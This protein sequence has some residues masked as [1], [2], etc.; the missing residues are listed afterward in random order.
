MPFSL[1]RKGTCSGYNTIK[2]CVMHEIIANIVSYLIKENIY[3]NS[4]V[5]RNE[6]HPQLI[7]NNRSESIMEIKTMRLSIIAASDTCLIGSYT[8]SKCYV[9]IISTICNPKHWKKAI[10]RYYWWHNRV[11]A[12]KR[13][14]YWTNRTINNCYG[15]ASRGIIFLLINIIIICPFDISIF[16]MYVHI[17]ICDL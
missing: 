17:C 11:Y 12:W 8:V 3:E 7:R 16:N 13:V 1:P 5:W 10:R 2:R 14:Y 9:N 6:N 15:R 4:Y